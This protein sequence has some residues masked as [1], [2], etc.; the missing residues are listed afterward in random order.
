MTPRMLEFVEKIAKLCNE[1]QYD[2]IPTQDDNGAPEMWISD[3]ELTD[4]VYLKHILRSQRYTE[5]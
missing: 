3:S 5:N 1:Y 2:I 4:V